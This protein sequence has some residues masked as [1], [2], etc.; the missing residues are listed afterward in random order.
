MLDCIN[1]Q[2]QI[3][4]AFRVLK[5]E[6]SV[7]CFTIFGKRDK[8][9]QFTIVDEVLKKHMNPDQLDEFNNRK[10]DYDLYADNGIQ[11][12]EDLYIHGF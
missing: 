12:K 1:P 2:N 9:L 8:C 5:K 7:A 6:N 10:S 3:F 11:L 4:E